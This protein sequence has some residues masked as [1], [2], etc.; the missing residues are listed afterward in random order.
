MAGGSSSTGSSSR[1]YAPKFGFHPHQPSLKHR[2][3]ATILGATMWFWI[4]YRARQDGP[5]LLGLRHPWDGHH[6]HHDDHAHGEGH[7]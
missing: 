7:H 1:W 6:G 4:F 5:V 2:A 3:G